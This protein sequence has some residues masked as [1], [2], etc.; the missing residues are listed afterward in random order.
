MKKLLPSLKRYLFFSLACAAPF[1]AHA[2]DRTVNLQSGRFVPAV[3]A[4]LS[5]VRHSNSELVNGRY[6]RFVQFNE[7]LTEDQKASLAA[8]GMQVYNYIPHF[9]YMVSVPASFNWQS[10]AAYGVRAVFAIENRHKLDEMLAKKEYPRWA[11]RNGNIELSVLHHPDVND[12]EAAAML[13]AAGAEVI[14]VVAGMNTHV[15]R[16]K[17]S[18]VNNIA[19]LPAVYFIEPYDAN[20]KPDNLQGRT[21]HRSNMLMQDFATGLKYDGTGVAVALN[22]DGV[23]GPHIDYEGR[24]IGQFITYNN[25]DH[26]DH[27]AG[28]IFGAGNRNPT[29]RGM[30]SG[31][32][33]GVYGVGGFPT[34]YQAFDSISSHYTKYNVRITSTSYSNGNNSGYTSLAR[35]MDN[36]IRNMPQLMHVFSSGNSGTSDFGYGAGAGWGNITGGHKQAK[37]VMTTG[38][39]VYTD[40]LATSSSR[41]PAKDGRIK[42]DI[43]AVGTDVNSTINPNTYGLKTGTSMACPGI[44][45]ALAQLYHAYKDMNSGNN[46][47]SALIKAAVLNTADDLGNAGPD[48]RFGWG[49]INALR[50]YNL[51][52]DNKYILAS[53]SQSNANNHNITVP[54]GVAE[55]RV[56][57]YWHDYEAVANASVALVN[58]L[59]MKV[60]TPSTAQVLPWIL[61][62]APNATTLNAPATQ[63]VDNLNNVEQVTIPSPAAGVYTVNVNGTAVPQGPQSYYVVYEFVYD[64]ITVIY[65]SGGEPVAPGVAETIRWDAYGNSGNFTVQYSINNGSSWNNISTSVPGSQRYVNWTPPNNLT[66][67]A[68]VRVTRGSASD[69]SDAMFSIAGIPGSLT[70][71]WVCLDSMSVSYSAVTGATGYVVSILGNK[72]M[73]SAGFSTTTTCVVKG[74][75]TLAPGWFSV[76]ALGPN[77]CKGR[78]ALAQPYSAVPYNCA[79]TMDVS[80]DKGLDPDPSTHYDCSASPFTDTVKVQIKNN[81]ST[82]AGNFPVRYMVNGGTPVSETFTGTIAPFTTAT[83]TFSQLVTLTTAGTQII[84]AWVEVPGDQS[85]VNDTVVI[86]K[87]IVYPPATQLPIAEDFEN[88]TACDTSANCGLHVCPLANGWTNDI[89]GMEDSIDWRINAGP[90]PSNLLTSTTGPTQDFKPGTADGQYAYLE[91]TDCQGKQAN[92]VSPCI[93]LTSSLSPKL[94]F[95]YHMFG[96]NMGE[97]HVDVYAQ[98][99]WTNDIIAPI[100]GNQGNQWHTRMV[101]LTGFGGKIVNLRFRGVTGGEASDM[102]IDYINV[103][104]DLSVQDISGSITAD[105]FPNPSTGTYNVLLSG[106]HAKVQLVVTDVSGRVVAEQSATPQS[107]S[108]RTQLDLRHLPA[109]AYMLSVQAGNEILNHKLVKY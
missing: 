62:P 8:Q 101:P 51:L 105:V 72:Y 53:I 56:M 69:Q 109:G 29:T 74:I 104:N 15:I 13:E 27:C 75:N 41:G 77:N 90:T 107:G 21:N 22:D 95:S 4:S 1:F 48:Y 93:D 99:V 24:L 81:A 60:I 36:Q 3:T 23:I 66:G 59:D 32:T 73:D 44:S 11:V 52:K 61:N 106:V 54:A 46:P 18:L 42:P 26:G 49:R 17:T 83:H 5:E 40:A 96:S 31:A 25:G 6:Y 64:N 94:A 34:G 12:N 92:M 7:I 79:I 82:A 35:T 55:L 33:L 88:F 14:H 47:N 103:T 78:R 100:T 30:A 102:A 108:L 67:Q 39:L 98:G 20:P 16:I 71:N 65:P 10:A 28:T 2:Q 38:N 57:V 43:C 76:H 70:V 63:G 86:Q 97:L 45:G 58:N 50:A 85:P 87:T 19:N 89:N 68:L 9:T 84:K 37:N 80:G 91:A